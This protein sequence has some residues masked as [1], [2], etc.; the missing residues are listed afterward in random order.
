M[1]TM[2][3]DVDVYS[4][5]AEH[6]LMMDGIFLDETPSQYDFSAVRTY[7]QMATKIRSSTGF[8]PNPLVSNIF[9][10]AS[11]LSFTSR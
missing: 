1:D 6:A 11:P 9:H 3:K 5:W 4:A 8:G 7:E 10:P 2:I